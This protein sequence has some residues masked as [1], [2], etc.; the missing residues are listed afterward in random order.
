MQGQRH[1]MPVY[2]DEERR[3]A[4]IEL[5]ICLNIVE[6]VLAGWPSPDLCAYEIAHT[7]RDRL[8]VL[9]ALVN[10]SGSPPRS[11]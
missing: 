7:L 8:D 3:I 10:P 2:T 5:G 9:M 4:L 11:C 6:K 1:D